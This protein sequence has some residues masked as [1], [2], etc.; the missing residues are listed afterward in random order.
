[1]ANPRI[2]TDVTAF[3][4][5]DLIAQHQITVLPIEI[6]FGTETFLITSRQSWQEF[7]EYIADRPAEETEISIPFAAL[8]QAFERL[9]RETGEVLVI[10][11][12]G[13]LTGAFGQAQRAARGFL[14]RCRI[15]LMDSM[16]ISWGLGLLV[17]TAAE[18]AAQGYPLDAIIRRVRGMLPHIYLIFAVERLDYLERGGRLGPAQALLGSLLKINPIL[19]VEDGE[20]VPVEKVRTRTMA[21]EK[22]ADFVAEFAS[23][24]QVVLLKSPLEGGNGAKLGELRDLLSMALPGQSFETIEYDPVLACHL[25]PDAVGVVVYEGI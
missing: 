10:P 2:V 16:S 9:S 6:R 13:S 12:S 8:E 23:I 17:R 18:A 14:G 24:Q 21:L 7:F 15:Q 19:L 25:G 4:D 5:P 20:I 3:L 1:M 11:S 22:L